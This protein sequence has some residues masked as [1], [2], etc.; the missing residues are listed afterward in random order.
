ME[1]AVCVVT[2]GTGT[3]LG[4]TRCSSRLLP[5]SFADP[6]VC[7]AISFT[8]TVSGWWKQ[9]GA[10]S[11][12]KRLPSSE[13]LEPR[14]SPLCLTGIVGGG[15]VRHLLSKGATVIAPLRSEA[16]RPRLEAALAG[17]PT[18]RLHTVLADW[19]REE[20]ARQLATFV[21]E[22][23]GKEVDHVVSIS[24]GW[25]CRCAAG[26]CSLNATSPATLLAGLQSLLLA[27]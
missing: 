27:C 11:P 19:G 20:G 14:P 17:C 5:L 8:A 6:L 7:G 9:E 4:T 25:P 2:G 24:G 12:N 23:V 1:G 26:D 16:S 13:L 15:V 22:E 21:R 3:A 10:P 18:D